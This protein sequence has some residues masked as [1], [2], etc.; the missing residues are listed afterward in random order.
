MHAVVAAPVAQRHA[1]GAVV[2]AF[3][4]MCWLGLFGRS[5]SEACQGTITRMPSLP[6]VTVIQGICLELLLGSTL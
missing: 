3:C 6:E 4:Y 2:K 5:F 1:C